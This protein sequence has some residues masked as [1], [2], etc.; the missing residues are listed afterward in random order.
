M[1]S[2]EKSTQTDQADLLPRKLFGLKLKDSLKFISSL[3]LPLVL[4]VFTLVIT[5]QQ[6][7]LAKQQREQDRVSADRQR[8]QDRN[9]SELQRVQEKNLNDERYQNEVLNNYIKEMAKSLNENDGSLTKNEVTATVARVKTLNIFRQLDAKR[10][11]QI[12]RFL[13][14]AKQL[15]KSQENDSLDLSTAELCHMDFRESAINKKKLNNLSLTGLFVSNATFIGIDMEHD[16]FSHTVFDVINFSS[17]H[18]RNTIF[19]D[20]RLKNTNFSCSQLNIVNLT[21]AKLENIN[22]CFTKLK[23]IDFVQ[24]IINNSSFEF[25]ILENINFSNTTLDNLNFSSTKLVNVNFSSTTLNNIDFT[26]ATLKNVDFS[27]TKLKR[28]NFTNSSLFNC[29][30]SVSI[31]LDIDFS[32]SQLDGV[33]FLNSTLYN[34]SFSKASLFNAD[35]SLAHLE[36]IQFLSTHLDHANFS[37]SKL[38]NIEFSFARLEDG[39]FLNATLSGVR[40]SQASILNT[41]M[42]L[43]QLGTTQF[44]SAH[45]DHVNFSDALLTDVG[46]SSALLANAILVS[47][48]FHRVNF[49][50]AEIGYADFSSAFLASTD[51]LCANIYYTDFRQTTFSTVHFIGATLSYSNFSYSDAK[52]ASFVRSSLSYIDFSDANFYKANFTG[53]N[54]TE[55]QFESALSIQDATLPNGTLAHDMNLIENGQADCNINLTLSWTL[56]ND[57]VFT[58]SSDKDNY[59]CKFTLKPN[60]TRATISQRVN[61]SNKWSLTFWPNSHVV[62]SASMSIGVSIQLR[63]I[64]SIGP[65]WTVGKLSSTEDNISLPLK[66]DMSGL[67]VQIE[68]SVLA[69]RNNNIDYWCDDI[70]LFIIYGIHPEYSKVPNA[71]TTQAS[72]TQSTIQVCPTAVWNSSFLAV[73]GT[74]IR[75]SASTLLSNPVHVFFDSLNSMYVVDQSSHR[76]QRFIAGA[77]HSRV[78][79]ESLHFPTLGSNLGTTVAGITS[80]GGISVTQLKSPT[81]IFVTP[82]SFMYIVDNGN[83]RIQKWRIGEPSGSTVAGGNGPGSALSQI[84]IS[85]GIYIHN[86]YNIYVSDYGNHRVVLWNAG[87]TTGGRLVAGGNGNGNAD[88]QLS[89]PY[90]IYVDQNGTLY[91]AEYGN[92][93]ISKWLPSKTTMFLMHFSRQY[94]DAKFGITIAGETAVAAATTIT[95]ELSPNQLPNVPCADARWSNTSRVLVNTSEGNH[96]AIS[97]RFDPYDFI[98]DVND[99]IYV[100]DGS[101]NRVIRFATGST[102]GE[103]VAGMGSGG[104]GKSE[105]AFPTALFLTRNYTLFI[106]DSNN[107]RVQKWKYDE[108]LGFTVAGGDGS[109]VTLDKISVSYGLYVDDQYNVYVSEYENHRVTLW[110]NNNKTIGRLVAGGNGNGTASNQLNCPRGIHVTTNGT[111]Y[112]ADYNNHRIQKWTRDASSGWTVAGQSGVNGSS[113][114]QLWN[115][116]AVLVDQYNNLFILD[117]RNTRIQ[118]WPPGSID[119]STVISIPASFIGYSMRFD[120]AGNLLVVDG[121]H[122]RI[123]SFPVVCSSNATGRV[124][125]RPTSVLT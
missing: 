67:E 85:Y 98:I 62:L 12:I 58:V 36:A 51:F 78:N 118:K 103:I 115:P 43:A 2:P 71:A 53:A 125:S 99:N 106:A 101:N 96:S 64:S 107:S 47:S 124:F 38:S 15:D 23:N 41:D 104:K 8:E 31:L 88:N 116:T 120:Q 17:T 1:L 87:N 68:F 45:L 35:L 20:S 27:F 13:Y 84:S 89:L 25:A 29:N 55:S 7:Q 60:R 54:I 24:A 102:S 113:S 50:S 49:S 79:A 11:I 56:K 91:I 59:N 28:V 94:L 4:G 72:S 86:E 32:V 108:P 9:L 77:L 95:T 81:A 14:E 93:I 46:F 105:L 16:N 40:F 117:T 5:M 61:L 30:F 18:M 39:K 83:Q 66:N 82:S 75:G 3:L 65:V 57:D 37:F 97:L 109:G 74:G 6:Q 26:N 73:A 76:I 100:A 90:G 119:G 111:I 19:L 63:V 80:N 44:P 21:S 114:R 33:K 70:R 48:K 52:H 22:F 121:L 122:K 10:N 112:I 92:H 34:V 42:S 110:M 69:N 123:I